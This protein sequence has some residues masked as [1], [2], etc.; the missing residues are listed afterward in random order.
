MPFTQ[1]LYR[2]FHRTLTGSFTPQSWSDLV[3]TYSSRRLSDPNDILLAISGIADYLWQTHGGTY[4]AG[5]WREHFPGALMWQNFSTPHHRLR[6][7]RA[8]SWSWA[9]NYGIMEYAEYD[10]YDRDFTLVSV[11]IVLKSP[12]APF[13]AVT[14]GSITVRGWLRRL[15]MRQTGVDQY[16]L[17]DVNGDTSADCYPDSEEDCLKELIVWCLQVSPYNEDTGRGPSG[18]I[19]TTKDGKIYRRR[20]LFSYSPV[21][22]VEAPERERRRCWIEKCSLKDVV[23]E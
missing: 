21:D 17:V 10:R 20:G 8:P 14:G 6:Q 5:L 2:T 7:Y 22:E 3:L 1:L 15:F 9:A 4:M 18:I 16:M 12:Q 11:D 23:I 19:L 13:G